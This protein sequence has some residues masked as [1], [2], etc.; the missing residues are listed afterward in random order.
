LIRGRAF[1]VGERNSNR[2]PALISSSLAERLWPNTDPIGQRFSRAVPGDQPFE[3]VGVLGDA[4]LTALDRTPPYMVYV[5]YWWRSHP[6]GSLLVR[7]SGDPVAETSAI[8]RAVQSLDPDIAIGETVSLDSLVARSLAGRRYQTRLFVVFGAVALFI[9]IVGV[10][11][12]TA[13][14]VSRR[15][16]EMNIR[17]ALG[18]RRGQVIRMILIQ[19]AKGVAAGLV[20]GVAGAVAAGGVIASLLFGVQPR[21]P[22]VIAGIT[23]FVG[24]TAIAAAS[25]AASAGLKLDP[26]AALREE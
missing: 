12:V 22:V 14:A 17:T 26:A 19:S 4:R 18:A 15:R 1:A 25:L 11:A 21:D 2:L 16:R 9:A 13:Y 6:V 10:Y 8:H 23:G 7:S 5:P 20:V 3:V 24:L